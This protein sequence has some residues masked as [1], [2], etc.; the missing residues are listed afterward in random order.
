MYKT[1]LKCDTINGDKS[2]VGISEELKK[3]KRKKNS[4]SS[5]RGILY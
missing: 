3:E 4:N 5:S 1:V 2:F